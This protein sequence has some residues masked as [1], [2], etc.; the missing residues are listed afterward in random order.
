MRGILRIEQSDRNELEV[1]NTEMAW[2]AMMNQVYRS[3][4]HETMQKILKLV[5]AVLGSTRI[6]N[7]KSK[8]EMNAARIA[9]EAIREVES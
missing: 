4:D 5:D 6:F 2:E 9:Y 1:M 8:M 3:T 7:F